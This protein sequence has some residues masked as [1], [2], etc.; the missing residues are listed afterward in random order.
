M[1]VAFLTAEQCRRYG[2]FGGEPTSAQLGRY[3]HLDQNDLEF[4]GKH[5]RDHN[6]L[7]VAIQLVTVRFLG[8]FLADPANV[9]P[10]RSAMSPSSWWQRASWPTSVKQ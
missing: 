1:P 6:R 3:F 5:R 7:G 9:P 8:T 2:R 10:V 4:V